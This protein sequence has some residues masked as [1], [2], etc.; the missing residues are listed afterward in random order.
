[1]VR[2]P[3]PSLTSRLAGVRSSATTRDPRSGTTAT[4][5]E[6]TA[7]GEVK[8]E[9]KSENVS[10]ED[11]REEEMIREM[12]EISL[13]VRL[14]CSVIEKDSILNS[15]MMRSSQDF[16]RLGKE[17]K[18]DPPR[19][20]C[21]MYGEIARALVADGAYKTAARLNR[22]CRAVHEETLPILYKTMIVYDAE[23]FGRSI[24]E[25]DSKGFKHV[26]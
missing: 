6:N 12:A 4:A 13:S 19:L 7:V 17:S 22:T 1:M 3:R 5:I 26:K 23:L 20:P 16:P 2:Q 15:D 25:T 8:D 9:V 21:D 11:V 18:N 10:I 24:G 14:S